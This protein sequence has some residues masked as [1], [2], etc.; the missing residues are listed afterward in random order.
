MRLFHASYN[1]KDHN[2]LKQQLLISF[3]LKC[4]PE[5]LLER[6]V[7][8]TLWAKWLRGKM[9]LSFPVFLALLEKLENILITFLDNSTV[10]SKLFDNLTQSKLM[11]HCLKV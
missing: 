9:G 3:C 10:C 5:P 8:K 4:A 2:T 1:D 11:S 6:H 7:T